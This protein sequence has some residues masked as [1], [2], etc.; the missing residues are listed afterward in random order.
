MEDGEQLKGRL[1]R[2]GL[3]W[4]VDEK[5]R[6]HPDQIRWAAKAHQILS[7]PANEIKE[8]DAGEVTSKEVR[9]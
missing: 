6:V 1:T 3:A 2:S 8:Q 4:A 9:S 7:K 5:D